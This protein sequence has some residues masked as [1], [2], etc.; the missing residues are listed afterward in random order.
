M[1]VVSESG[2]NLYNEFF[3]VVPAKM[4]I[5]KKLIELWTCPIPVS[6]EL[7]T[8]F[9]VVWQAP[10]RNLLSNIIESVDLRFIVTE[11][12]LEQVPHQRKIGNNV[13]G[14]GS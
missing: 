6:P 9:D 1:W 10:Q 8:G 4:Q 2:Q 14:L 11:R 12:V 7:N 13:E 3:S 5:C